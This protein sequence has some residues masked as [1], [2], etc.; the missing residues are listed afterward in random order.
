LLL[1]DY[2][3]LYTGVTDPPTDSDCNYCCDITL[4]IF[5]VCTSVK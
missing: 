5:I 4:I 3:Y 2:L 1:L